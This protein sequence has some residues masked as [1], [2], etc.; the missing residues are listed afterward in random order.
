MRVGRKVNVAKGCG[1]AKTDF[2][3]MTEKRKIIPTKLTHS[4]TYT[5]S[6]TN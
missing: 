2:T 4:L 6:L 3:V 5:L 1:G